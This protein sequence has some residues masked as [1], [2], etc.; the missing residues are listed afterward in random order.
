MMLHYIRDGYTFRAD[1]DGLKIEPGAT[2]DAAA[3]TS[4]L[5]VAES[6]DPRG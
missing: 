1:T 4:A 5:S 2:Q 3:L 6:P